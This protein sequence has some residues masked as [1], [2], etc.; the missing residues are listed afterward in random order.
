MASILP[1][2]HRVNV[3]LELLLPA[4]QILEAC[5]RAG[6]RFRKR[7]LDPAV[8][9]HILI[10]Q[11]LACTSLRGV[12]AVA[13]VK[14]TRQAINQARKRLPLCV[15]LELVQRLCRSACLQSSGPAGGDGVT[16]WHGHRLVLLDGTV[17]RADDTPELRKRYGK[18]SNQ[19]GLSTACPLVR[20]LALLDAST[21][22]IRKVISMPYA[23]SEL[24]VFARMLRDLLLGDMVL[25]DRGLVSFAHLALLMQRGVC[26]CIRLPGIMVVHGQGQASRRQVRRL[27]RQ[28]LLVQWRRRK[29]PTWMSRVRFALLPQSLLLRQ[30]SFRLCR[31]GFRPKWAWIITDRLDPL[32]YPAQDLVQLYGR[33]W[34]VE[35]DFRDLKRTLKMKHLRSRR[36]PAVRKELAAFVILYN[37]IRLTMQHSAQ[38]QAVKADRIS[39]I[40]AADWLLW[41]QP[42]EQIPELL[43][44]PVRHRDTQP[45]ALKDYRRN[46]GRLAQPRHALT[47]PAYEAKL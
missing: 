6:Y 41:G 42:Q 19:R 31:Q 11:L 21:G 5:R 20:L 8:S 13:G 18:A 7:V 47:R 39:F 12:R 2:L 25:A 24:Q 15:M 26:F 28:D 32:K 9:V 29:R 14:V 22:M 45:R 4:Q 36:V 17:C 27:G 10:V 37:L 16:D 38:Q 44:N 40:D 35:V 43:I 1:R 46:F 33:R 34:Q 23:G 30:I 3:Q